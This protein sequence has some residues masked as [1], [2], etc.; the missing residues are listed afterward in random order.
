[1]SEAFRAQVRS[2]L[3]DRLLRLRRSIKF[4]LDR[5]EVYRAAFP[6]ENFE[7]LLSSPLKQPQLEERNLRLCTARQSIIHF[8]LDSQAEL[9]AMPDL[10]NAST[11][12]LYYPHEGAVGPA[13]GTALILRDEVRTDMQL[14]AW[15]DTAWALEDQIRHFTLKIYS[16]VKDFNNPSELA[17]AWPEV[18]AAVPGIVPA[19]A[20]LRVAARSPRVSK[21]RRR[22][23]EFFP[24]GAGGE[25]DTFTSMLAT[26]LMLPD[27]LDTDAWVGLCDCIPSQEDY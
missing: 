20:H 4:P 3:S 10:S 22:V 2:T 17:L 21:L 19:E 25:M 11:F 16:I 12:W 14:R 8:C 7:W 5:K 15:Y 1:M 27:N 26:A 9:D 23:L 13:D 6:V 24:L 18:A